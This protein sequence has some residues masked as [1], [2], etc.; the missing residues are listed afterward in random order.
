[1][2]ER[3]LI[4]GAS[5][6][7]GFHLI[8]A[9]LSRG[10]TVYAAVRAGSDVQHLKGYDIGFCELNYTN[11]ELLAKQLEE[12]G[13]Q[14]IIHAA[15]TTRTGS[16]EAYNAINAGYA[17]NLAR[18]AMQGLGSKLLKFVFI[19]SLAAL[20]PLNNREMLITEEIVPAPVTAYGR[21]KLLAER[22]LQVLP[23]LP[24]II[25]RPTAVYGPRE[26]D[27]LIILRA[28]S[29]GMEAYIGKIEQ[30]LS[31]VYVKDLASVAINAL[32][33]E[34]SGVAFNIS[35]G[36]SYGQ[37]ELAE[38]SKQILNRKTWRLHVPH[39]MIK[40]LAFGMERVYGWRGKTPALNVE[41]LNELTA[42]NWHCS[43][44][45]AKAALGFCPR[46]TLEQGLRE[47]LHWYRQHNWI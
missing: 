45:K 9:A 20:G 22:Q 21:S 39:G 23:L 2:K 6:F 17:V 33:T 11:V 40:A 4:T 43:I 18:A 34:L 42:V 31:F 27:I 13:C 32:C 37:Y 36:R 7:I 29:R 28:I 3:I 8:E 38:F 25:L 1:M 46:Y 47:T 24:L 30:Q 26:K 19:S 10:F 15:G 14:Y 41:K 5:G 35:D 44:D 16:Q 12:I